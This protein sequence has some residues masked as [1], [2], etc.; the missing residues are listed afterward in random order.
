MKTQQ[1]A[2]IRK[3]AKGKSSMCQLDTEQ[4]AQHFDVPQCHGDN[5]DSTISRDQKGGKKKKLDMLT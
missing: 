5:E 4:V 1:S 2:G 3:G